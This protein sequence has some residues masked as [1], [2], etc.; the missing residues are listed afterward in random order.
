MKADSILTEGKVVLA[1]AGSRADLVTVR[2]LQAVREADVIVYDDLMDHAL[3]RESSAG[4]ELIPVGKRKDAH[5]KEQEEIEEL[6]VDLARAGRKVL[7]LKGGD[8]TVFGRGG[9]EALTLERAGIPFEL[10]PGVSSCIAAPEHMGI[11]ITQRGA[12]SSFA[13]VTGH[14]D[15]RTAEDFGALAR[16]KGTIVYLMALS[17]ADGIADALIAA[18]KDPETPAS[19]L[20]RV[21]M[22]GENRLDG[23]LKDL[24]AMARQAQT[25]AILVIGE[26]AGMHLKSSEAAAKPPSAATA[27]VVGSRSFTGRMAQTL[28]KGNILPWEFACMEIE[29]RPENIPSKPEEYDWLVFTSANGVRIFLEE[30]DRRETDLRRLGRTKIACIGRGTA[31]ELR[32]ARLY[33][34]L[35][36]DTFTSQAL[37]Q[38]LAEAVKPQE[39]VL[40]L[41][42]A[43]GNPVLTNRLKNEKIIYN[44]CRI[45]GTRYEEPAEREERS[46][47]YVIFASAGGVRCYLE[48]NPYPAGAVPVCIG[49]ITAEELEKRTG[50]KALVAPEC[51]AEGILQEIQARRAHQ[52]S[53][54]ENGQGIP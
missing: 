24:G 44:D 18:G 29:P 25:P 36:P 49:G 13:V 23:R 11:S 17:R 28:R 6:L 10:I 53:G 16:L 39:K 27:L 32:K 34:D 30:M 50:I 54:G 51:S 15:E 42:A 19:V 20:S 26:T 52:E 2:A 14:C 22:E 46:Y 21:F 41:R 31:G 9:E 4:C 40:I 43:D 12:A 33:A 7:R 45:Y 37:A 47:E 3:L 8:P 38:A 1:G 5:K 48:R 35:I